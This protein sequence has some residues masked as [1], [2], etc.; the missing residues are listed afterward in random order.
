[1]NSLD[2]DSLSFAERPDGWLPIHE[3][4]LLILVGLTG[5]GKSTTLEEMVNR[6]DLRCRLLPDHPG[7]TEGGWPAAHPGQGSANPV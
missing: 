6:P 4:N 7:R 5:V 3:K 1:M 2:K